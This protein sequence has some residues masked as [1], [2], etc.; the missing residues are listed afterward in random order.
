[1]HKDYFTPGELADLCGISKSLLLHYDR[2]GILKPT[3]TDS[4]GFRFYAASQYYILENII[5]LRKL[6]ISLPDIKRFLSYK[7]TEQLNQLYSEKLKDCREK[8]AQYQNYEQQLLANMKSL[9][10]TEGVTVNQIMLQELPLIHYLAECEINLS[11]PVKE[12]IRTIAG[13]LRP[14]LQKDYMHRFFYGRYIDSRAFF[15]SKGFDSYHFILLDFL[16]EKTGTP[17]KKGLYV[18]VY[19]NS[20]HFRVP[21]EIITALKRFIKTNRL[22]ICGPAYMLPVGS[23]HYETTDWRQRISRICIQ[24][25]YTN[26]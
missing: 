2:Q 6:D 10:T 16:K 18:T 1:M 12:R 3:R 24:V 19:C 8:I 9:T 14:Y 25:N 20:D 11:Q 22:T 7:S 23:S 13:F 4:K 5:A 15:S 21:P 17:E 26:R